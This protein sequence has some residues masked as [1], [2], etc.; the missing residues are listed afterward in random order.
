MSLLPIPIL[1]S[2]L[3][4][5]NYLIW[6]TKLEYAFLSRKKKKEKEYTMVIKNNL[7]NIVLWFVLTLTESLKTYFFNVNLIPLFQR[8]K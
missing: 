2:G 5:T 7:E 1:I 6:K 3:L 4:L 8:N